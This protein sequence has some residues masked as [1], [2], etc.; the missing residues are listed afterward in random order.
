MTRRQVGIY[1]AGTIAAA[2]AAAT[3]RPAAAQAPPAA[4]NPGPGTPLTSTDPFVTGILSRLQTLEGS[5]QQFQTTFD[6]KLTQAGI[7]FQAKVDALHTELNQELNQTKTDLGT[8]IRNS[9]P[10]GTIIMVAMDATP[11]EGYL[12]CD[13]T[14]YKIA[15]H[16]DFDL[17]R[18]AIGSTWGGNGVTDFSVPELRGEFPRFHDKGRSVD[19]GRPLGKSQD[20][21]TGMP[22]NTFGTAAA[23]A[24]NHGGNTSGE[25]NTH[26]H[27]VTI[28]DQGGRNT[29]DD[30]HTRGVDG[31]PTV[32]SGA[33]S[34]DHTHS[35]PPAPDHPH[36]VT[37]GDAETRPRN[38]ALVGYIKF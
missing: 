18:Q 9:P 25:S 3:A 24:H 10:I 6:G 19:S 35:I 34:T 20:W 4:D 15:D 16:P 28:T 12:L 36:V 7:D 31:H 13:G 11:P 17:L 1:L 37:G 21:S 22:R 23:G 38:Q 8:R 2:V 14:N 32:T 27:Q 26:T 30:G 29:F 33:N 5:R